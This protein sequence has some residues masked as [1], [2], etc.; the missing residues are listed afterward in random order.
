MCICNMSTEVDG[1]TIPA[2]ERGV[3]AVVALSVVQN[4]VKFNDS[5]VAQ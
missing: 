4:S 2:E 5:A 1:K 3:I